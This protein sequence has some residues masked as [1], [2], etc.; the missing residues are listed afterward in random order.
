MPSPRTCL[1]AGALAAVLLAACSGEGRSLF[2]DRDGTRPPSTTAPAATTADAEDLEWHDC[3]GGECAEL[4]VPLD[5][6]APDGETIDVSLIRVPATDP[7]ERIGSLL[8]NPGG[9]GASGVDFVRQ[10]GFFL[11]DSL[12]EHFD[13]VGF[14][15]RGTGGTI[16]VQ[17]ER[18]L[19][20]IL[21]YDYSPDSPDERAS[22]E[23]GLQELTAACE[24]S[25]GDVLAHVSSQDTVRDMDRIRAAVGDEKLT[26]LGFSYGTYLGALY[27]DFFPDKVRALALDGAIDPTV[28]ALGTNLEQAGGFERSLNAF[29]DDCA[30]NPSCAFYR[31]GDPH[32][33]FD[34]LAA[35]IDAHPLEADRGRRLG[36]GEFVLGVFQ[37]LYGGEFTWPELSEALD[38]ADGG[39]PKPLLALADEYSGRND[40][41]SYNSLLEPFW[42]IGC[43]DAPSIGLPE[44]YP[45]LEEQFRAAAPRFGVTFLYQAMVCSYWPAPAVANPNPL[46]TSGTPPLL[47]I[48]TLG[49]PATPFHWAESLADVLATAVLVT[50]VGE[51]H[52][53]YLSN[54]CATDVIHAYLIDL[55]VPPPGTRCEE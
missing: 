35:E 52:T 15:P 16:P 50:A 53:A 11:P 7:D 27:A 43:T 29:L 23:A 34:A 5:Y 30:A 25:N 24:Q 18:S 47:V 48:G 19:D 10:S 4:T 41:G 32:A 20:E 42:S 3:D 8:I 6:A 26:Y 51:Q 49:D 36:P 37:P 2:A 55:E 1:V 13:L 54:S 45:D 40:D 44:Q 46:D 21:G 14:D 22:L 33:A 28:D 12:R 38:A 39:K 31:G 17:C 9:P